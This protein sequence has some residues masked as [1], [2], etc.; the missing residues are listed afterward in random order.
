MVAVALCAGRDE[1]EDCLQPTALLLTR[2]P[3]VR[4]DMR[5]ARRGVVNIC[6]RGEWGVEQCGVVRDCLCAC[7]RR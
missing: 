4:E 7:M 5:H 1:V 3:I 2:R 6:A